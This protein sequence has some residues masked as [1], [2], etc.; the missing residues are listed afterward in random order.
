M[1]IFVSIVY[2][3]G[4]KIFVP[5]LSDELFPYSGDVNFDVGNINY[6]ISDIR[7]MSKI[8]VISETRRKLALMC[9]PR[10]AFVAIE[11]VEM[12]L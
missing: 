11:E 3:N 4:P 1:K 9:R 2:A 7:A 12:D 6:K 5:Q 8:Q 10:D